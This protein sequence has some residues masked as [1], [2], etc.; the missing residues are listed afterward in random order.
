MGAR[1]LR[2]VTQ[3][4][5]PRAEVISPLGVAYS[6]HALTCTTVAEVRCSAN[7]RWSDPTSGLSEVQHMLVTDHRS[8]RVSTTPYLMC[9]YTYTVPQRYFLKGMARCTY[10]A[11]DR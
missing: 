9:V 1:I 7:P 6:I 4:M 10:R 5:L 11:A 2:L 8:A 3:C